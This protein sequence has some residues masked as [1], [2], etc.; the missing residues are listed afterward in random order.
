MPGTWG[1]IEDACGYSMPRDNHEWVVAETE[2]K[3][4]LKAGLRNLRNETLGFLTG[5]L[6]ELRGM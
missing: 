3:K 6:K 2:L 5:N 4:S 1:F